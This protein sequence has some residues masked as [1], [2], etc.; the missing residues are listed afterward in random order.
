MERTI[1]SNGGVMIDSLDDAAFVI[2]ED[3]FDPNI[4][5]KMGEDNKNY[6]HFRYIQECIA[7][8]QALNHEDGLYLCPTPQAL[9]VR[10]F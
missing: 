10:A 6:V 9:P 3:G 7:M 2:Q 1:I 8:N 4:W 5:N